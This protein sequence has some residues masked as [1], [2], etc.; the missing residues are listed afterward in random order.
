VITATI[1]QVKAVLH[2]AHLAHHHHHYW[3]LIANAAATVTTTSLFQIGCTS[4]QQDKSNE[5][6]TCSCE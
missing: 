1:N 5:A 6:M 2:L 3:V 4:N